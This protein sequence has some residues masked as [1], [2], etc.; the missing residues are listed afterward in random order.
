M[1]KLKVEFA[2][3]K[4]WLIQGGM[5][6]SEEIIETVIRESLFCH[7][8]RLAGPYR[9]GMPKRSIE[10]ALGKPLIS[11]VFYRSYRARVEKAN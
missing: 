5:T 10:S 3:Y 2:E 6:A 7:R 11:S 8:D 4:S 9:V 1:D